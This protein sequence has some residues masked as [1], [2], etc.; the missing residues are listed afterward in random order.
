MNIISTQMK[1]WQNGRTHKEEFVKDGITTKEQYEREGVKLVESAVGGNI[2]GHADGHG[3]VIRYDLGKHYFA[4]GDP[5]KGLKTF[6]APKDK[7]K[8]YYE[9]REE[10]L[11]HGGKA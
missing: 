1:H 8:Y 7:D 2:I 4:K 5:N 6:M 11:K 10:D 3:N 9:Q